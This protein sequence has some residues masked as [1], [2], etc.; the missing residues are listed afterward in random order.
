MPF[1]WKDLIPDKDTLS[2]IVD[3][4]KEAFNKAKDMYN[5]RQSPLDDMQDTL[6]VK[7]SADAFDKTFDMNTLPLRQDGTVTVQDAFTALRELTAKLDK[8]D[9]IKAVPADKNEFANKQG[10]APIEFAKQ[11]LNEELGE[12][13]DDLT[14]DMKKGELD[15]F[16]QFYMRGEDDRLEI[17][18]SYHDKTCKN[19][20]ADAS[21]T[22][23]NHVL[24][25]EGK[26]I[27]L[28][29]K[30]ARQETQAYVEVPATPHLDGH[31]I[32]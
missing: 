5:D 17:L 18:Q 22:P 29:G 4:S 7:A 24:V 25:S 30:S 12:Y 31:D 20:S 14:K 2:K 19:L 6:K 15:S 11:A 32:G 28:S 27:D 16:M 8:A 9:C 13:A 26:V 21:Q 1:G 3:G 10:I 23:S